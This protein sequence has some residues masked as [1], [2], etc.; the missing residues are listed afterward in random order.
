MPYKVIDRKDG[1]V[2]GTYSTLIRAHNKKDKLDNE[3]GGYRYG[4]EKAK[5]PNNRSKLKRAA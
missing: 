2:M 1:T 4:V 3:Y 5:K